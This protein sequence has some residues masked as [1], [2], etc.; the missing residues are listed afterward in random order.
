M[1]ADY[2]YATIMKR[3][4]SYSELCVNVG[5]K[6]HLLG[7]DNRRFCSSRA[8]YAC[9]EL[10]LGSEALRNR[11][12][13]GG[14]RILEQAMN[15][16]HIGK[17]RTFGNHWTRPN[18]T[19]PCSLPPSPSTND[20]GYFFPELVSLTWRYAPKHLPNDRCPGAGFLVAAF[21]I[22]IGLYLHFVSQRFA[23]SKL[24]FDFIIY[25][26]Y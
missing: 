1:R 4:Y 25:M 14:W 15:V 11:G 2:C 17:R 19:F 20:L 8:Q 21:V 3:D 23:Y 9:C 26:W 13:G 12:H 22:R 16:S 18:Q 5:S 7:F 10:P 6:K 24:F